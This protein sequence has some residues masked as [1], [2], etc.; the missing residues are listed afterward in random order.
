[1][2]RGRIPVL[3][4]VSEDLW[5][6]NKQNVTCDLGPK[7][8]FISMSALNLGFDE[9][10]LQLFYFF[11]KHC[12]FLI[13][14]IITHTR[15]TR[16]YL[17]RGSFFFHNG[18]MKRKKTPQCSCRHNDAIFYLQ[19]GWNEDTSICVIFG[20][21]RHLQIAQ[22]LKW[23]QELSFPHKHWSPWRVLVIPLGLGNQFYFHIV[24]SCS[25]E[26]TDK[27]CKG[28]GGVTWLH[29]SKNL[30]SA[31]CASEERGFYCSDCFKKKVSMCS[32]CGVK[33]LIL[34]WPYNCRC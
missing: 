21:P 9:A 2:A 30:K 14:T 22:R 10:I 19:R 12:W 5:M 20:D 25:I 3:S 18:G 24:R 16:N 31:F 17:Y 27:W 26:I 4:C 32:R 33:I 34:D 8:S 29:I 7:F 1:M 23:S 28:M 15:K 13:V 11:N 6:L